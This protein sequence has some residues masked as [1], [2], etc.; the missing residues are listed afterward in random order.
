MS[1]HVRL[2]AS[3]KDDISTL[4]PRSAPT[5][6]VPMQTQCSL[7]SSVNMCMHMNGGV[8]IYALDTLTD[9][10]C[11]HAR[12]NTRAGVVEVRIIIQNAFVPSV[13]LWPKTSRSDGQIQW[14]WYSGVVS[15][16]FWIAHMFTLYG[17]IFVVERVE[18]C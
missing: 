10:R 2:A 13:P 18:R 12:T 6:L 8:R 5:P 7:V 4:S 14:C 16:S 17:G 11:E 9:S 15:A 3:L 1:A